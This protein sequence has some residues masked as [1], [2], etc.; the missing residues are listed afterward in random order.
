MEALLRFFRLGNRIYLEHELS[1]YGNVFNRFKA[2]NVRIIKYT[3][4]EM[5]KTDTRV[6]QEQAVGFIFV[7]SKNR[8][9]CVFT[10]SR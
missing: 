6:V 5:D 9:S 8:K 10:T 2:K 1:R 3:G 4:T 7:I